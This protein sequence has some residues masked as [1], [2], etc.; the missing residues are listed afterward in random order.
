MRFWDSSAIIP[1][2]IPEKQSQLCLSLIKKDPIMIVWYFT[3]TEVLSALH[4]KIRDN[5][6][7]ESDLELVRKDLA[8]LEDAWVVVLPRLI[9]RDRAHRLLATHPLRAADAL[10]LA[11]A[12]IATN[13]RPKGT[14]FVTFDKNLGLAAL[15]EGFVVVE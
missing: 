13:E 5:T 3:P 10:Q 7:D 2:L 14:E 4:R 12:I 11:A 8:T 1:L 9:V 6:I 15:K